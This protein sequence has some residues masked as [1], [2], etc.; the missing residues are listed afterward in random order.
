MANKNKNKTNGII[1]LLAII[2]II[3]AFI[4]IHSILEETNYDIK[5]ILCILID[6]VL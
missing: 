1:Y 6:Y 4:G 2:M 5:K 3:L